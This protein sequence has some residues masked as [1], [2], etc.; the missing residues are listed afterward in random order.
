MSATVVRRA[1]IIAV[2][3]ELKMMLSGAAAEVKKLAGARGPQGEM[4]KY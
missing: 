3:S 2:G 4:A 1:A